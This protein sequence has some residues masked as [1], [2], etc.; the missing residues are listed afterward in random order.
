MNGYNFRSLGG[1]HFDRKDFFDR[2]VFS[3]HLIESV[4]RS[5]ME[6]PLAAFGADLGV[7]IFD[8]I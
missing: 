8:N 1:E 7:D 6:V 4:K 5:G 2:V 3:D